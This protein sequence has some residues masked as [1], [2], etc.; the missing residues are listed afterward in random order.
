M[1]GYNTVFTIQTETSLTASKDDFIL[2][3]LFIWNLGQLT[4]CLSI[5]Q[6]LKQLAKT[7]ARKSFCKLLR[8]Q[9]WRSLFL[10]KFY[11]FL[12]ILLS[13]KIIFWEASYFI[14]SSNIQV[15]AW[16]YKFLISKTFN[17]G[18]TLKDEATSPI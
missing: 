3:T 10:V 6:P 14:H 4:Y 11:A 8:D 13:M 9:L 12:H 1:G 16:N 15:A 5:R 18:S 2:I 7:F 17:D